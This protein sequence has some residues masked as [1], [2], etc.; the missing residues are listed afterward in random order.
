MVVRL[1]G[2]AQHLGQQID[3]RCLCHTVAVRFPLVLLRET[4]ARLGALRRVWWRRAGRIRCEEFV[5]FVT[6]YL[7]GAV[8]P[9]DARRFEHHL[10]RCPGCDRYLAQL[11]E[12]VRLTG[13]LRAD[14]LPTPGRAELLAAYEASR[15]P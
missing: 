13:R 11:R 14:D 10:R 15:H 8:S 6:N 5:E 2:R 7:D 4:S 1:A 12:T 3:E 9:R